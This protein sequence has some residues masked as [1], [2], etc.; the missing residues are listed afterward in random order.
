MRRRK[1]LAPRLLWRSGKATLYM[2][3]LRCCETQARKGGYPHP[4]TSP[5]V[6]WL[7]NAHQVRQARTLEAMYRLGW[8]EYG[9]FG[10]RGGVRW[11]LTEQGKVICDIVAQHGV[12]SKP[13]LMLL[14]SFM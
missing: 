5:N 2:E 13:I 1:N 7:Y 6:H 4:Y 12:N 8:V 10:P 3:L 11:R 14:P 9:N